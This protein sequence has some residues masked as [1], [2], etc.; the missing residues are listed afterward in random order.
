M[1]SC[2]FV[3]TDLTSGA[4]WFPAEA[5]VS[6]AGG[7][8]TLILGAGQSIGGGDSVKVDVYG[9][10][11]ITSAA[12]RSMAVSTSSDSAA[13]AQYSIVPGQSVVAPSVSLSSAAAGAS[14]VGYSVMFSA[15]SSG[16][17]AF[18]PFD[19]AL[20]G[21]ITLS[22]PPG[23]FDQGGA[24]MLPYNFVIS[25]RT[26]GAV[27]SPASVAVSP[28]ASSASLAI[29]LKDGVA[30]NDVL[31]VQF[32]GG[33][34]PTLPGTYALTVS[35]SSDTGSTATYTIVPAAG[36]ASP[37][38]TLSSEVPGASGVEYAVTLATSSSGGL[39]ADGYLSV[40]NGVVNLSAAAGT[41]FSANT[42]DYT[43]VD[44]TT[45]SVTEPGSVALSQGGSAVALSLSGLAGISS[46]DSVEVDAMNVVNAGASCQQNLTISTSSDTLPASA[47]YPLGCPPAAP[48][49]S[50]AAADDGSVTLSWT[51]P[52]ASAGVLDYLVLEYQG[53][54]ASGTP[55]II[56]T[57][58]TTLTY[59]VTGLT[60]GQQYAFTVEAQ[61]QFGT[62]PASPAATAEPGPPSAP[63]NLSAALG[64]DQVTL[65]W[66]PP[67]SGGF[68]VTD[69]VVDQYAG[70]TATGTPTVIDIGST[71]TSYALS[72]L[73]AG[74]QYTFTVAAVDGAGQG[75]PTVAVTETV[76]TLPSNG[77]RPVAT[78]GKQSV[79]LTWSPPHSDGYSPILYY[80]IDEYIGA[81]PSGTP[82]AV[83]STDSPVF[84]YTIL[85]LSSAQ[86]YA[87]TLQ[88]VNVIGFG[89]VSRTVVATAS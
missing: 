56:D 49:G 53:S 47:A 82:I 66:G 33:S 88:A 65:A 30:A 1:T 42:Y 48:G 63:A 36:V 85:G 45:G 23:M 13:S 27:A 54:T 44:H 68:P 6:P 20:S 11:N 39:V 24:A 77:M 16:G 75:P 35:S 40:L 87:F 26:S 69:Y 7:T 22:G 43:I 19:R 81:T 2:N 41:A 84:S 50:S 51:P 74:Q 18:D 9:T 58:S 5:S 80:V 72:G 3:V 15:S 8:A 89:P 55:T 76:A 71:G 67:L 60:N 79:L 83:I 21:T 28:D 14:Q 59:T 52:P 12:V 4:S 31:V 37:S 70:A 29:S 38:V 61:N 57:G 17:L 62:G 86:T 46:G 25:D 73:T 64:N 10:S 34:N 32:F 78:S